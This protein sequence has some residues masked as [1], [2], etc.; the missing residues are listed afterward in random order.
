MTYKLYNDPFTNE[1][2]SIKRT[3][4]DGSIS[5]IHNSSRDTELSETHFSQFPI[6]GDMF[7]FGAHTLHTVYPFRCEEEDS[8]RRSVSFNSMFRETTD[9][10]K[11]EHNWKNHT[12]ENGV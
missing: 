11:A 1:L 7:I 9:V 2:G 6:V 10:A 4:D 12:E 3:N 8:E 5:F